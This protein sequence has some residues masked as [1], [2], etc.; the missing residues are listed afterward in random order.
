MDII[1]LLRTLLISRGGAFCFASSKGTDASFFWWPCQC[2]HVLPVAAEMAARPRGVDLLDLAPRSCRISILITRDG[3]QHL[4]AEDSG[5]SLQLA[6]SGVSILEPVR[7][8]SSVLWSPEELKQRLNGLECLNG[9]WSTGRLPPR[10]FPAEPR[11]SRLRRVLRAL[12]GS[13]AGAPHHEIGFALFGRA[14]V[15]QDWAEPR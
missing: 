3:H 5:R 4:L 1:S 11:R 6:A 9:L 13:I 8:T 10:F 15:E 7:L 14:R 12:D 2:P